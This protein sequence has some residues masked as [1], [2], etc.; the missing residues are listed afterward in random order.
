VAQVL[1]EGGRTSAAARAQAFLLSLQYGC[2]LP[3]ALRGGIAYDATQFATQ[4][5][6]GS[7]AT[8][9][10]TDRRSTTQA[11]YGLSGVFLNS[12]TAAEDAPGVTPMDCDDPTSTPT[13]T[14]TSS[15]RE[16]PATG[17]S[18]ALETAALGLVSVFAGLLLL[19]VGRPRYLHRH[20]ARRH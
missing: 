7:G 3:E 14:P 15:A 1:L 18:G 2:T 13:P 20:A 16:L 6:A 10:D 11:I 19:A 12:V 9:S 8:V 5:K 17:A 4:T